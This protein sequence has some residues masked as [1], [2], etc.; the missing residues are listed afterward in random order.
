LKVWLNGALMDA[1]RACISPADHGFLLGDGVFETLRC[2]AGTPFALDDHL[3]RL[4]AGAAA[5]GIDP[6]PRTVLTF[7]ARDVVEA[8]GL[9][10]AR[11][12]ITLTSGAGPP[13]LL[14]DQTPPTILI[15]A[16]PLAPWPPTATAVLS[17]WRR[18]QESPLAGVKTTSLAEGVLALREARAQGADEGLVLNRRGDVCEATTANVFLVRAGEVQTPS[19]A[20][21]CLAGITR[22]RALRLSAGAETEI[23]ATALHD[24]DELFLT[25]STREI[26]PLVAVDGRPVGTGE[27]GEITHRLAAAYREMVSAE[28]ELE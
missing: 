20:S 17:R 28:L 24:A 16:H 18:D 27:P 23:P 26:Q 2:Y 10:E 5:L 21:G 7:A 13:G 9:G 4:E 14:R 15:T 25:S 6:P 8:N 19:L 1:D 3:G 22:D 11:M 12:R